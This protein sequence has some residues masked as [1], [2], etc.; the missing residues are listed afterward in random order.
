[1]EKDTLIAIA[2]ALLIGAITMS[3]SNPLFVNHA[4]INSSVDAIEQAKKEELLAKGYHPE[5]VDKTLLWAKSWTERMLQSPLYAMFG[6]ETKKAGA[7]DLYK[8]ALTRAEEWAAAM[9]V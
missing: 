3:K 4:P 8:Y 9:S 6:P 1:M 5:L 2:G 7:A